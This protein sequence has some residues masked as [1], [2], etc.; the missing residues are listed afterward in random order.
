MCCYFAELELLHIDE[1]VDELLNQDRVCDVILP[2]IQKRCDFCVFASI[3]YNKGMIQHCNS[4][5]L[6]MLMRNV[7][8]VLCCLHVCSLVFRHILEQLEQLEPRVSALDEDLSGGES[9]EEEEDGRGKHSPSPTD[10]RH[11]PSHKRYI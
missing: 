8:H 4:E 11:S 2:R 5:A 1:F 9:D 3:C 6:F 7:I 10:R